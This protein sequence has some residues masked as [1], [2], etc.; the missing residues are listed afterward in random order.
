[1]LLGP[2]SKEEQIIAR[3][4]N[5]TRN[6][7]HSIMGMLELVARGPL[8]QAQSEYLRFCK[9]S[10]DRLLRSV[11]NAAILFSPETGVPQVHTF[12]LH[13]LIKELANLMEALAHRKGL[14][15]RYEIEST[16]PDRI[17]GDRD[18][19][20]DI[21][22]RL[23][24]NA[25]RFTNQ[26]GI[27]L[28]ASGI[29]ENPAEYRVQFDILDTGPGIPVEVI[30]SI[31]G[32]TSG[33]MAERGLGLPIVRKLVL[34]MNGELLF[35]S[36]KPAGS[37]VTVMLPFALAKEDPDRESNVS[38]TT[39]PLNILVAEDSDDSY[40]VLEFHLQQ[41]GHRLTRAGNGTQAVELFK[42]GNYDLVF[43]DVHMP[44]MD[45]Y[46]ATRAIR[47]WETGCARARVPIVVLSSDSPSTQLQY[48]AKV[49]CSAYLTKPVASEA[50]R[51]VLGRYARRDS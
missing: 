17:M 35:A 30:R 8:T 11:Q 5:D 50:L 51:T 41:E 32:E 48:G 33:Y 42:N 15:L 3:L 9:S 36:Q 23:L 20:Q 40:Y 22:V 39:A 10:T 34:S 47:I 7:L 14:S 19:L 44:E 28:I 29:E 24:E 6:E 18:R 27:E 38:G 46:S 26:G 1:M 37:R 49:G 21:L 13:E 16:A 45:G 43:M 31:S 12:S 25:V 4:E 2:G